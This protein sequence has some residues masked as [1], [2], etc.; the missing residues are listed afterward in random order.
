MENTNTILLDDKFIVNITVNKDNISLDTYKGD[1]IIMFNHIKRVMARFSSFDRVHFIEKL[2]DVYKNAYEYCTHSGDKLD[3][4]MG[5]IITSDAYTGQYYSYVTSNTITDRYKSDSLALSLQICLS[6]C[7]LT[8]IRTGHI[9]KSLPE[10][11]HHNIP[12]SISTVQNLYDCIEKSHGDMELCEKIGVNCYGVI[13]YFLSL[14]KLS[15]SSISDSIIKSTDLLVPNSKKSYIFAIDYPY[16]LSKDFDNNPPEFLFHGS[17]F[18][19]WFEIVR[20]GIKNFSGTKLM[21]HGQAYGPG[22]Y[23]TDSCNM[24]L[25]YS[26]DTSGFKTAAVIQVLGG[27]NTYKKI[28]GIYVIPDASKILI[29]YLIVSSGQT[30]STKMVEFLTKTRVAEM[31]NTLTS[32]K[33]ITAKRLLRDINKLSKKL[34][35]NGFDVKVTDGTHGTHVTISSGNLY[36][37]RLDF[38]IVYPSE[39][40]TMYVISPIINKCSQIMSTGQVIIPQFTK[41]KWASNIKIYNIINNILNNI[42]EKYTTSSGE[43]NMCNTVE[44]NYTEFIRS[45]VYIA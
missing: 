39:Y 20:S 45:V 25:S 16:S 14:N 32:M 18:S 2:K 1:D 34:T 11:L 36:N 27:V 12:Y 41:H 40:P 44:S 8:N 38:P 6:L 3:T 29:R 17:C 13:K 7:T 30:P 15:I 37:F 23:T 33:I 4:S 26:H 28:S 35:K 10:N 19:N 9:I 42:V 21:T 43:Y 24:A 22:I 5:Q 31:K